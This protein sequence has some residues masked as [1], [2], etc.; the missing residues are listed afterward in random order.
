MAADTTTFHVHPNVEFAGRFQG[1][2]DLDLQLLKAIAADG[3]IASAAALMGKALGLAIPELTR[4]SRVLISPDAALHRVPFEVLRG[5]SRRLLQTHVVEGTPDAEPGEI[6]D[7]SRDAIHVATGSGVIAIDRLQ[8]EGRRP[9][10]AREF[11]AGRPLQPGA[12][13]GGR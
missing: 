4:K 1:Q 7:V 13:F 10:G 3:D 6:V 8:A 2:G 5:P 11:L 9:V 12:R